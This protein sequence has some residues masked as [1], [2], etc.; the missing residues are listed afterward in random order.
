VPADA[1]I[2]FGQYVLV[3]R[4][5]R[6]GMAEVFLAQ[7]RGLEGFDRRV[8]VKR[9]LPHLA[10]SPDFVKM[11]LGEAKLAAQLSHPNVV[12]IYEFGKV[13]HDYFI[14]MEFVDGVHAGQLFKH[15]DHE[16]LPVTL[17]ARIG[18]DAAAAL[19]YAH[20]LRSP[21]GKLYGLVHRDVS[22]ANI[23]VSFDGVVK[24]CDFGIAKAAA[25]GDQLTNPGQVK[26]KYAYMSPEQTIAGQL[27]GRSD[28]FS[29]AIVLWELLAGKYIVPRGDPIAAM[30]MIRDGK[31]EP[32]DKVAPHVPPPLAKAINWALEPKREKR[33]TAADLAQALEAFIKASPELATPMQLSG[34][35]RARFVREGTG[36]EPALDSTH[37]AS[38]SGDG[39][40]PN[41]DAAGPGTSG[42]PGTSAGPGTFAAPRTSAAAAAHAIPASEK[43]T[44]VGG[45]LELRATPS[46]YPPRKVVKVVENAGEGT[47]IYTTSD[48][49]LDAA[50]LKAKRYTGGPPQRGDAAGSSGAYVRHDVE[51]TISMA[52]PDGMSG[53]SDATEVVD[54]R[55]VPR[56]SATEVVNAR[57]MPRPS[58]TEVVN[59]RNMPR[60]SATEVVDG[61][62][63]PRPSVPADEEDSQSSNETVVRDHR[64]P[65]SSAPM[66]VPTRMMPADL[67]GVPE[68][69]PLPG[70]PPA[71]S[72]AGYGH[73]PP[74]S[75][76]GTRLPP[77]S[78]SRAPSVAG[79]VPP[80]GPPPRAETV[81]PSRGG[82]VPP[83]GQA[84]P[85]PVPSAY[86]MNLSRDARTGSTIQGTGAQTA[87][88]R[89]PS[90]HGASP[91]L[92]APHA[93]PPLAPSATARR[94]KRIAMVAGLSVLALL[95]FMIA[96]AASNS[97]SN[98]RSSAQDA[99]TGIAVVRSGDT[100]PIA[101]P[102][103]DASLTPTVP[104]DAS[105]TKPAMGLLVVRT[106]PDGGTIKVGDQ[107]REAT[108][109]PGDP[110][111]ARTAQLLLEAGRYTVEAQLAG[112]Q[113]EKRDVIIDG[114]ENK[115]IE[116]TFTKRL[117]VVRPDRGHSP[118]T[119]RLT[120]RTTPWSDVYL[121]AKKLGQAPFADLEVAAGTYTL[122][123]RNPARPTVT[124]TVTI[125]AGKPTK[126]NFSLP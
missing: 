97:S 44:V 117:S 80:S 10:D 94:N 53:M 62:H 110:T 114:G 30:R 4:I 107:V 18:A 34:W 22:P 38:V 95:S 50:T 16:R 61:R 2:R 39:H 83:S 111:G 5:A 52:P 121:G 122:T 51:P 87:M 56:P 73:V 15:G 14:A 20:E 93:A 7:Q 112:Y 74:S 123:F 72:A 47:E 124:K 19:H 64:A 59:A 71:P 125:K 49:D 65:L 58:A 101:E 89:Q 3:R 108:V 99:G 120:V 36:K 119:G 9:I 69:R 23:M 45:P 60:P 28:V 67:P 42:G 35:V 106:I 113:P 92:F 6:G 103:L 84:M 48:L 116:V 25:A 75:S 98:N 96:L 63:L 70:V 17:V 21:N 13:E 46:S 12:H 105:A 91:D 33:A 40:T 66:V 104:L 118:A 115:M 78:G 1:G 90:A 82:E 8:A 32:L 102:P 43:P 29:L 126:L 100:L 26:G 37:D 31:L 88:P 57:N 77:P 11:F 24:L 27:D 76:R 85:S 109:Q 68:P 54:A 81:P 86:P 41:P 55:H 79:G